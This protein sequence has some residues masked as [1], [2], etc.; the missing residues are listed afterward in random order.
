MV[1]FFNRKS[2]RQGIAVRVNISPSSFQFQAEEWNGSI[3]SIQSDDFRDSEEGTAAIFHG[4]GGATRHNKYRRRKRVVA[5]RS[6]LVLS[7]YASARL[8]NGHRRLPAAFDPWSKSLFPRTQVYDPVSFSPP[9][10]SPPYLFI[11]ANPRLVNLLP[12]QVLAGQNDDGIWI[13]IV[14]IWF[15]EEVRGGRCLKILLKVESILSTDVALTLSNFIIV[16]LNIF[17]FWNLKNWVIRSVIKYWIYFQL[18]IQIHK[19]Y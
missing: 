2:T 3:Q 12:G 5:C 17:W 16:S 4:R 19:N 1:Y 13:W 11:R 8:P 14:R 18:Y 7:S 15:L 9:N 6:P 10:F